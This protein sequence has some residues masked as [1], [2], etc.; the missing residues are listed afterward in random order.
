MLVTTCL[1]RKTMELRLTV[2]RSSHCD[3]STA[4]LCSRGWTVAMGLPSTNPH[5]PVVGSSF[6][7]STD[8]PSS[9]WQ[10][11]R[12]AP[13][14]PRSS[15]MLCE[16]KGKAEYSQSGSAYSCVRLRFCSMQSM[17]KAPPSGGRASAGSVQLMAAAAWVFTLEVTS[18]TVLALRKSTESPCTRSCGHHTTCLYGSISALSAS[19]VAV[20]AVNISASSSR[21]GIVR[22]RE[23]LHLK[24]T[25]NSS[26][27]RI[28]LMFESKLIVI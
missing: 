7:W 28:E 2:I 9:R 8:V 26:L 11:N 6:D 16:S 1:I 17:H 4:P 23:S 14:T 19:V 5:S 27:A 24:R 3:K 22:S 12:C 20:V 21:H 25:R 15:V 13:G 18:L 10:L